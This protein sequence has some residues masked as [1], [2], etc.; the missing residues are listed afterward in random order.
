[1]VHFDSMCCRTARSAPSVSPVANPTTT[2][3]M[4][5]FVGSPLRRLV[6]QTLLKEAKTERTSTK[7]GV[8]TDGWTCVTQIVTCLQE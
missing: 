8:I 7:C 1:M 6:R 4:R 3:N 2:G 5:V